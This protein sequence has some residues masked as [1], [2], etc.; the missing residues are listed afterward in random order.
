[1]PSVIEAIVNEA[2]DEAGSLLPGAWISPPNAS[3]E[4]EITTMAPSKK[5]RVVFICLAPF[6]VEAIRDL[7]TAENIPSIVA[8]DK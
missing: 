2:G 5:H 7:E 1:M 6:G 4:L 3:A 8:D